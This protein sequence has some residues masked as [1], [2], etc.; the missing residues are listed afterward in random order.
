[1]MFVVFQ[2]DGCPA[3]YQRTVREHLDNCFPNSW[4]GRGGPIPWRARSPDQTSL[5]FYVQGHAKE[6]VYATEVPT[7]EILIERINAAF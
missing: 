1:M 3:H 6:L 5:D 7:K 4:I 2:N